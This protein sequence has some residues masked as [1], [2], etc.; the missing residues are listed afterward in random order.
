M[1]NKTI[2]GI[3]LIIATLIWGTSLVA[4]RL[5]TGHIGPFTFNAVRFLIGALA[6]LPFIL[7]TDYHKNR[8]QTSDNR[9]ETKDILQIKGGLI[10]GCILF[11]TASLQQI[12]IIYTTVGKA[13]FITALYVVIVPVLGLFFGR[14]IHLQILGCIFLATFGMYLLCINEKFTLGFGDTLVL[15]CA[16][17]TAVHILTIDY[18]SSKVDC[19]KLS[20]LQF[21]VC[22]ILSSIAAFIFEKPE[23][24]S[25]MNASG[26]IIYT[27]ILSCGVAYTLQALGQKYVSPVAASLILSLESVFSVLSGWIMLGETLSIREI[28]GCI[29]MFTAIIVSQTMELWGYKMKSFK[30]DSTSNQINPK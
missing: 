30:D 11:A 18:L 29:M 27:G 14:H 5:A 7:I 23:L 28:L 22:G 16:F 17:S 4:Q 19:V 21:F 12:G 1:K 10:C 13:G 15:I 26:P 25:L 3:M 2:G 6:L 24:Q 20:C 9:F 8:L